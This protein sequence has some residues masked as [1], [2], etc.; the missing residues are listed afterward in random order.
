MTDQNQTTR[1]SN[2]L[3]VSKAEETSGE[4]VIKNVIVI[5]V[6]KPWS[7]KVG[8]TISA[9][10]GNPDGSFKDGQSPISLFLKGQENVDLAKDLTAL[11]KI[12]VLAEANTFG[13]NLG[14][15][16]TGIRKG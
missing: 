5:S 13:G 11:S 7:K 12:D 4:I 14:L 3:N 6:S 1:K 10:L 9:I 15:F 8:I 2:N 16:V